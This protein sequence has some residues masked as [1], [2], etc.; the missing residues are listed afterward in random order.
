MTNQEL[1]GNILIDR[2]VEIKKVVSIISSTFI[3]IIG[4]TV[5][6]DYLESNRSN[7][8]F[9]FDESI[10]FK[11]IWFLFIPILTMLYIKLQRDKV[12]TVLKKAIYIIGLVLIHIIALLFVVRIFA[13]F[14][15]NGRYDL[16]KILT[17]TVANDLYKLAFVYGTFVLSFNYIKNS[18]NKS[19]I[20]EC[21]SY[22]ESIIVRNGSQNTVIKVKDIFHLT[23]ET[24]YV[25][26][27]LES[28]KYLQTGTLKSICEQLD[29]NLYIRVHKSSIV[30]IEKVVSFKSR[31]NGDY[32]LL[33]KNGDEIRLSRTFASNFKKLFQVSHPVT[34]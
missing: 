18:R 21:N 32:D 14:F 12:D 33:L 4:V 7:Y 8:S 25:S 28:K 3:F 23:A 19:T 30:N 13:L 27:R 6:Q 26:I 22:L 16:Y 11:T 29:S 34:Q 31:L 2:A 5:F 17:Y 1:Q 24:P 15:F 10:L 20:S 9:N